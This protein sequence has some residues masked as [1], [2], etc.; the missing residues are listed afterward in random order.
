METQP[1][2]PDGHVYCVLT[3]SKRGRVL[4]MWEDREATGLVTHNCLNYGSAQ[5]HQQNPA[6]DFRKDLFD[7]LGAPCTPEEDFDYELHAAVPYEIMRFMKRKQ[8]SILLHTF[9]STSMLALISCLTLYYRLERA[10]S[11][12]DNLAPDATPEEQEALASEILSIRDY[13]NLDL[14]FDDLFGRVC[15]E[16]SKAFGE[17]VSQLIQEVVLNILTSVRA[18]RAEESKAAHKFR[19]A[20]KQ[21]Q[22]QRKDEGDRRQS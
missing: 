6:D 22:R 15:G 2:L 11:W 13:V 19:S 14:T 7:L 17:K 9:D 3:V 12:V 4:D 5:E 16:D 10:M 21:K 20:A 1:A 8:K 18:Y